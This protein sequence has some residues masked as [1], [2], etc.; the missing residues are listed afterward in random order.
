MEIA[1]TS[2]INQAYL[3]NFIKLFGSAVNNTV[4]DAKLI[5]FCTILTVALS[6]L[7][8]FKQYRL[9][10][11]NSTYYPLF[12]V[13]RCIRLLR[14]QNS[15]KI[16]INI[17]N[18][19][20]N[21]NKNKIKP[22]YFKYLKLKRLN[23]D[24]ASINFKIKFGS[25]KF[26]SNYLFSN[27]L[28]MSRNNLYKSNSNSGLYGSNALPL[29]NAQSSSSSSASIDSNQS[30][31][32][33]RYN[34]TDGNEEQHSENNINSNNNDG[35]YE[36]SNFLKTSMSMPVFSQ[37]KSLRRSLKNNQ[38]T[39]NLNPNTNNINRSRSGQKIY[40]KRVNR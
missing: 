15:E 21:N 16:K 13:K 32:S 38:S 19:N 18:N 14:R 26:N 35:L 5:A 8:S 25:F 29:S 7:V 22:N 31:Y 34:V 27:F 12:E 9:F 28:T 36:R 33:F 2:N 6:I 3:S 37:S 23:I 17:T 30:T 11:A 20:N 10:L 1:S 4:I 39:G 40:N 24:F